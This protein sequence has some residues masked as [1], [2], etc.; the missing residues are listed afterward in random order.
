MCRDGENAPMTTP[1][2]EGGPFWLKLIA[3]GFGIIMTCLGSTTTYFQP[4]NRLEPLILVSN[5]HIT[6]YRP[7]PLPSVGILVQNLKYLLVQQWWHALAPL[8]PILNQ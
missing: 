1:T 7:R 8:P 2:Y 6:R 5:H 4:R 3:A